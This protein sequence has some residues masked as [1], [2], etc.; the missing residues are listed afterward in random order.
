MASFHCYDK[1]DVIATLIM[2]NFHLYLIKLW[3]QFFQMFVYGDVVMLRIGRYWPWKTVTVSSHLHMPVRPMLLH[4]VALVSF[5]L[6]HEN[7]GNLR[8]FWGQ[9]VYCPPGKK[10]PVRLCLLLRCSRWIWS[11]RSPSREVSVENLPGWGFGATCCACVS[12]AW[13]IVRDSPMV[14]F[15]SQT[16]NKDIKMRLGH[17]RRSLCCLETQNAPWRHWRIPSICSWKDIFMAH[18]ILRLAKTTRG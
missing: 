10:L 9:M 15:D 4:C 1:S 18:R 13:E 12:F 17:R 5:R 2:T 14:N 3:W 7:L 6:F 8:E 11:Q 16:M